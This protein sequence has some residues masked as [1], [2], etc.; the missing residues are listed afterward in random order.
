MPRPHD[1]RLNRPGVEPGGPIWWD[2]GYHPH[3][4]S[5]NHIQ[6]ICVH[7]ADSLPKLLVEQMAKALEA[8]PPALRD[9]EKERRVSTYLDAGH[10]DCV[11]RETEVANMVQESL[12][13]FAGSRYVLHEWCIMPNHVHILMRPANGITMSTS[14]ASW[15]K[16]TGL[17]IS[18]WRQQHWGRPPAPVWHREYFDRYIRDED[19]YRT[20]VNYI[21][22]N[23]VKAGLVREAKAWKWSSAFE[24]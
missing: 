10:G 3:L 4:E 6:H 9:A 1:R 23:P 18:R 11:L 2:R 19:H 20:V 22:Q 5:Q 13:H 17:R 8:I 15:K 21:R 14:M 12:L 7:L 24:G 16:F